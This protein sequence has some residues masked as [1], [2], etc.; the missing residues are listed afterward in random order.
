MATT[1]RFE[2]RIMPRRCLPDWAQLNPRSAIATI[3]FALLLGLFSAGRAAA[4]T[5]VQAGIERRGPVSLEKREELYRLLHQ[6]AEVLEKQAAVVK[7]VAKLIGPTVV[8][9]EADVSNRASLQ[10]GRGHHVEEAGSGV[11]VEIKRKHYILTNRHVIRGAAADGIR[12]N[13]ADG[14]RIH[15]VKV[16]DD[17]DTDV[18]VLA[19]DAPELVPAR[20]GKSAAM[21][22][23]DFVLAVGSPFGLSH[24]VTYGI[25]SAKGRRDL[26]LGDASVIFQDFLQTDAAINPG[27]SGGP[28]INLRGEVIG[29]NTAIA[30]NSGGNE[31]IGFAIPVDMFMFV[32]DQLIETGKVARAFLGVNLDS[33]FGPTVAAELGL[34]R[35]FGAR[36]NGITPDSPAEAAKLR[37]SDVILEFDGNLVEDDG[38]LV[39]LVSQTPVGKKIS[40]VVFRD[41]APVTLQVVVTDRNKFKPNK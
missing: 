12:L 17:V 15:P 33:K 26:E 11:I 21:E 9:I 35:P 41:R 24:S 30:S 19:V 1:H 18:A 28:L 27:N 29:I 7:T 25:I 3:L 23:G 20:L 31:G 39:N 22:I 32:A 40:L 37:V 14:R 34:P 2:E 38:H 16:W 5:T 36:V 13:L 6:Q 8:H 4:Q 10:Y